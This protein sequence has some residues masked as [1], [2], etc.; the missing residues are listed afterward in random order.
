ME[1]YLCYI[2]KMGVNYKGENLYE[3]IFTSKNN[4]PLVD[5]ESWDKT[6]ADGFPSPPS[7]NFIKEVSSLTTSEITLNVIQDS[8]FFG[9][10]DAVDNI[11]ALGWENLEEDFEG[12][13]NVKR[14][15]FHYG[16]NSQS[17]A[18][19]LYS[20]DIILERTKSNNLVTK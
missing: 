8:N 12:M 10:Y 17:V 16:E 20:R 14:L 4:L 15:V 11:I 5:G 18:D 1:T 13:E 9:V 2:N 19:K 3:F 6:P 7:P